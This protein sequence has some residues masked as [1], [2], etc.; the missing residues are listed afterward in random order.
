MISVLFP[1][2][3][4]WVQIKR[5]FFRV[6]RILIPNEAPIILEKLK[7]VILANHPEK[8]YNIYNG[9]KCSDFQL[10]YHVHFGLQKGVNVYIFYKKFT[11]LFLK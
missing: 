3:P 4:I 8:V 9:Y 2:I 6:S 5:L 11:S 10:F 1:M 7:I